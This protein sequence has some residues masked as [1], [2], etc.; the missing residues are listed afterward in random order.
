VKKLK[1]NPFRLGI[2]IA[3]MLIISVL[4][5]IPLFN[6]NFGADFEAT[7]P[8]G[9]LQA[10]GSFLVNSS[11]TCTMTSIQIAI[12]LALILAVVL[13]SKLFCSYICPIGTISEWLGK[14]G[15]KWKV[16]I[17]IS[18]NLDKVL[19]VLKYGLLFI[20]I[21][22]SLASSEL[23]CKKFCPYFSSVTGFHP[24]VNVLL[25]IIALVIV[26]FGS[27]FF[28]LFW[29]KYLC[30]LGAISNIFRFF[31]MFA[32]VMVV[33]ILIRVVG[34]ELGFVWPLA[35]ACI[36]G[37]VLELLSMRSKTFP[38]FKIK[39]HEDICTNCKL[40]TKNCPMAIE[41]HKLDTVKH[42]DCHMC[43]DCIEVC[44]EKG[45]LT[46]NKRGLKWCPA[47]VLIILILAGFIVGRS[48]ELPTLTEYW[49]EEG[50]QEEMEIYS[51]SGMESVKCFSSS[52]AVANHLYDMD[53]IYGVTT[54][55]KDHT[56]KIWYDPDAADTLGIQEW[57][58]TPAYVLVAEPPADATTL[59][60]YLLQVE[61]FFDS[62]DDQYLG[63]ILLDHESIYGFETDFA[64]PV[65]VTIYLDSRSEITKDALKDI[66]EQK[67]KGGAKP[68][69][70]H[71]Y[72]VITIEEGEGIGVGEFKEM[73]LE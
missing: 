26:V 33:Y 43:A 21:Y 65:K 6:K 44:P 22:F 38:L 34:I 66:V 15:E 36:L 2:Q 3:I 10:F 11:L 60:K 72:G 39:R 29:C 37:Y 23:F 42:I 46:I 58:F 25:G 61:N 49:G 40:C 52:Q 5:I 69:V 70:H 27:I 64:C 55:V 50:T 47:L 59:S 14:L 17:N 56:L 63:G 30:P 71:H 7:C 9:G 35:V 53:G 45:A 28:R 20:T 73:F 24:D 1:T 4:L 32:I 57:L 16:R 67:L 41:V 48:F 19:R 13:F 68:D 31:L 54:F 12:G 51:I 62:S 18:G 8:F